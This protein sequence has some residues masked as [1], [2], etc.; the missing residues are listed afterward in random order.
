MRA[1]Q[2][3][4]EPV[5][6]LSTADGFL[7]S[8]VERVSR[9]CRAA[10][11]RARCRLEHRGRVSFRG[12]VSLLLL[13]VTPGGLIRPPL[14]EMLKAGLKN[15]E[16]VDIGKGIHFLQEDNPHGIDEAIA[17]WYRRLPR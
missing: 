15:L 12:R 4:A 16:T 2:R 8:G 6:G 14:V 10:A 9:A 5:V 11:R 17:A 7:V 1:V 3:L 13:H